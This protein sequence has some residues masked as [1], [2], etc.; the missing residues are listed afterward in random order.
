MTG[1]QTNDVIE[2]PAKLAPPTMFRADRQS[3]GESLLLSWTPPSLEGPGDLVAT[4]YTLYCDESKIIDINSS[5]IRQALLKGIDINSSH[6][7]GICSVSK[8]DP[9]TVPFSSAMC[10]YKYGGVPK[11]YRAVRDYDPEID[12]TSLSHPLHLS[13]ESGAIEELEF[14]EGDTL[15]IHGK[16]V[17]GKQLLH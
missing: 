12:S 10:Y 5:S 2:V 1:S 11:P 13:H 9:A 4:G 7:L 14:D 16:M 6:I 17:R 8:M 3:D 15:I